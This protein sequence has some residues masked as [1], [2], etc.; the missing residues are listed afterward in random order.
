MIADYRAL[1]DGEAND[2]VPEPLVEA[3]ER[4]GADEA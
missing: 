4:R 3:T 2:N 1:L